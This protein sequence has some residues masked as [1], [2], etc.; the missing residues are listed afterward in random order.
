[1]NLHVFYSIGIMIISSGPQGR[2]CYHHRSTGT[3]NGGS[4]FKNEDQGES[5]TQPAIAPQSDE[6]KQKQ[7]SE[8]KKRGFVVV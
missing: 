6:G 3:K 5:Q 1:M 8:L 2:L 7:I 4:L